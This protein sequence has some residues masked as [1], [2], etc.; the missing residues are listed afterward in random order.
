MS[1][2]KEG[3]HLEDEYKEERINLKDED[4]EGKYKPRR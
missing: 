1:I 4:K 2:A 3:R